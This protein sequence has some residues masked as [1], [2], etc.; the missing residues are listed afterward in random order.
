MYK[1][2]DE[3]LNHLFPV[4]ITSKLLE[5]REEYKSHLEDSVNEFVLKGYSEEQS[6]QMAIS[7]FGDTKTLK[8][9]IKKLGRNNKRHKRVL[10]ALGITILVSLCT[11]QVLSLPIFL[12]LNTVLVFAF[13][14]SWAAALNVDVVTHKNEELKD[15]NNIGVLGGLGMRYKENNS[16]S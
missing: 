1:N 6:I 15:A 7:N 10:V 4:P 9:T 16:K 12:M 2:I 14:G 8:A 3:Y 5:I 11:I 13:L